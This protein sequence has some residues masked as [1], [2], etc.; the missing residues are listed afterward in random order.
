M[1]GGCSIR[2][3]N[4]TDPLEAFASF[5]GRMLPSSRLDVVSV[6]TGPGFVPGTDT[7]TQSTPLH[8][9]VHPHW[10]LAT[11]VAFRPFEVPF[12][13]LFVLAMMPPRQ[14]YYRGL[15]GSAS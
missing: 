11:R 1:T 6:D 14:E 15:A 9:E 3:I 7:P 8:S 2:P 5:G 13:F 10:S 12:N 4:Q